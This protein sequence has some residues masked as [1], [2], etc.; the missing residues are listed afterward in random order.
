MT[1]GHIDIMMAT[2]FKQ[3]YVKMELAFWAFWIESLRESARLQHL[4]RKGHA[5]LEA[6]RW[7]LRV[8]TPILWLSAGLTM[9]LVLGV[10][11]A[12]VAS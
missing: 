8:P 1:T 2:D 12:L 7:V 6:N 4:L 11:T 5:L 10:L 3:L 9:G